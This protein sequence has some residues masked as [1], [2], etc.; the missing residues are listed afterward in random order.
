MQWELQ[1][2]ST[3]SGAAFDHWYADL[4]VKDHMQDISEAADEAHSRAGAGYASGAAPYCS[5]VTC[6]PQLTGLP[7]SSFWCIATWAMK[8]FGAAPCQ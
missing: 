3:L 5:S 7:L 1:I 6:S 4:E 2:V 8:R